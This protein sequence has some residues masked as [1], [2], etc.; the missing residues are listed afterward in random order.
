MNAKVPGQFKA[1]VYNAILLNRRFTVPQLCAWTSLTREQVYSHLFQLRQEGFLETETESVDTSDEKRP[2]HRPLTLYRVTQDRE[3]RALLAQ[4]VAPFLRLAEELEPNPVFRKLLGLRAQLDVIES[5]ANSIQAA[6]HGV[7][8]R[9]QV[10]SD[11]KLLT[12]SQGQLNAIGAELTALA[13]DASVFEDTIADAYIRAENERRKRIEVQVAELSEA[14]TNT[15]QQLLAEKEFTGIL[16]VLQEIFVAWK[17]KPGLADRLREAL[18]DV[19]VGSKNLRLKTIVAAIDADIRRPQVSQDESKEVAWI[20][21]S[22]A[23]RYGSDTKLCIELADHA[24]YFR[25][26]NE[27]V[28]GYNLANLH[29]LNGDRAKA[30][31]IWH[32]VATRLLQSD[33]TARNEIAHTL[34]IPERL[35]GYRSTILAIGDSS[36]LSSEDIARLEDYLGKEGAVSVASTNVI[37]A[38]GTPPF[39]VKPTLFEWIEKD[40]NPWGVLISTSNAEYH[41][42]I[43][44]Y[45]PLAEAIQF[46][47]LPILRLVTSLV[48]FGIPPLN[49][50]EC[51]D[52]NYVKDTRV[53]VLL[54][55]TDVSSDPRSVEQLQGYLPSG[56]AIVSNSLAVSAVNVAV[57]V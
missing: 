38:Y 39:V 40:P 25:G 47:G 16:R 42:N 18:S 33:Q 31:S 52:Q 15:Y 57:A 22:A 2:A 30:H 19:F 34:G 23:A 24:S 5:R 4:R 1:A 6:L 36:S 9:E 14:V 21:A 7:K 26:R 8:E 49:A 17:E 50:W 43:F 37:N 3:K 20:L 53:L 41:P 28:T 29:L 54:H 55:K 56:F 44:V 51:L 12:S 46:P 27:N 10:L 45:G 35:S 13:E 11:Q 32:E 48:I